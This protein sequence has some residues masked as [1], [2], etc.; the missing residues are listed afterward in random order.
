MP[1]KLTKSFMSEDLLGIRDHFASA[2]LVR[3]LLWEIARLRSVVLI[4]HK[5]LSRLF[6]VQ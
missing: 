4:L 5:Q 1:A 2:R 3:L 6:V